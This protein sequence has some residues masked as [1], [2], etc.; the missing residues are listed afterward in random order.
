MNF[1]RVQTFTLLL[2]DL[3]GAL[4]FFPATFIFRRQQNKNKTWQIMFL[5]FEGQVY[6]FKW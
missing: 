1:K 3:N 2:S 6:R 4:A 5:L